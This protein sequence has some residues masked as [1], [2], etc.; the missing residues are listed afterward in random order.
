VVDELVDLS[1]ASGRVQRQSLKRDLD[2]LVD[3]YYDRPIAEWAAGQTLQEVMGI[4]FRHQLQ[5]PTDLTLL[6]KVL[7][8]SEGLGAQLDP[9]FKLLSFAQPYLQ[10]VWLQ[11]RSP[12]HL[13]AQVAQGV[14]DLTDLSLKLPERLRRL[15]SQVEQGDLTFRTRLEG[16]DEAL[17]ELNRVANRLAMSVLTAALII[18]LGLAMLIYHPQAWAGWAGWFFTGL[19]ALAASLGAGL[20]W[21]I[22]RSR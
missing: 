15:T 2:H 18:A 22:W 17:H 10:R 3:R 16:L 19:F 8:M 9:E 7:V 13:A 6:A 11:S 4:A 14:L 12:S 5:L 1:V 20:L 21:S